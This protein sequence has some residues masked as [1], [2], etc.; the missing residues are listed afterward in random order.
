MAGSLAATEMGLFATA[1]PEEA[2]EAAGFVSAEAAGFEE[3]LAGAAALGEAEVAGLGDAAEAGAAEL[4]VAAVEAGAVLDPQ[5]IKASREAVEAT[6]PVMCRTRFI[7][8]RRV[9][10]PSL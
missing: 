4:P 1:D 8:S 10:R 9:I 5:P 2:V 6:P 7:M 3:A